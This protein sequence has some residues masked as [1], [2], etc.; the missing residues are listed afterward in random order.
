MDASNVVTTSD[1]CGGRSGTPEIIYRF[2]LENPS[3]VRVDLTPGQGAP[4]GI[5]WLSG[6]MCDDATEM[7][8]SSELCLS[9]SDVFNAEAGVHYFSVEAEFSLRDSFDLEIDVSELEC[10]PGSDNYP[11]CMGDDRLACSFQGTIDTLSCPSSNGCSMGYC[12]GDVCEAAFELDGAGS[13]SF[14]GDDITAYTNAFD[15]GDIDECYTESDFARPTPGEDFVV[16]MR[17]LQAGQTVTIDAG[18]SVGDTA[19]SQIFILNSCADTADA[20][21]AGDDPL[22]DGFSWEVSAGGDYYLVV[23]R[24][25]NTTQDSQKPFGVTIDIQ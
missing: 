3:R 17:N 9:E 4:F 8:P 22:F 15:F 1:A 23:D 21:E 25:N 7:F 24:A 20:C 5:E 16:L 18:D 14:S 11:V 6:D 19:D 13:Y 10:L 2:E 12:G